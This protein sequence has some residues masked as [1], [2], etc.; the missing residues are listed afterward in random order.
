MNVEL[1]TTLDASL[2]D[3]PDECTSSDYLPVPHTDW[4]SNAAGR[5]VR[6]RAV[7]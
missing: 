6:R 4:E 2:A 7:Y 5:T 3:I 1:D